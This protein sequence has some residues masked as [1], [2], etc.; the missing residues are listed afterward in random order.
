MR[1]GALY[2]FLQFLLIGSILLVPSIDPFRWAPSALSQIVGALGLVAAVAMLGFSFKALGRA[3]TPNP[4]PKPDAGLV[5]RGLYSR[6]RHPM[7]TALLT[8]TLGWALSMR[9]PF[10]L[11]AFFN[12][13]LFLHSKATLEESLLV[14]K[15]GHN[16]EAYRARTGKFL[17]CR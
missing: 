15:F 7:Y 5:T 9:S 12:F 2:V 10:A 4:V 11:V 8:G 13:A 16:Y 3:T 6:I 17:P 1:N 14:E